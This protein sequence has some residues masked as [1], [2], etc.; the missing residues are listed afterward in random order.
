MHHP[1][2]QEKKRWEQCIFAG[3]PSAMSY[4]SRSLRKTRF[5]GL[6]YWPCRLPLFRLQRRALPVEDIKNPLRFLLE[7]NGNDTFSLHPDSD[8]CFPPWDSNAKQSE[9]LANPLH[10]EAT[11]C[12]EAC[13]PFAT[14]PL[15]WLLTVGP[16]QFHLAS[17]THSNRHLSI[18]RSTLWQQHHPTKAPSSELSPPEFEP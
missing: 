4:Q 17:W 3:K 5:D 6:L 15:S 14:R 12:K 13:K 9:K 1:E 7:T 8:T 18:W 2:S 11:C 10:V 16:H